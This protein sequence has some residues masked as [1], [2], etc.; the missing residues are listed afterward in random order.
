[1]SLWLRD[2]SI[3]LP[4]SSI[5]RKPLT[6]AMRADRRVECKLNEYH[7]KNIG[8]FLRGSER[9]PSFEDPTLFFV[10]VLKDSQL[11]V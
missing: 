11:D 5:T 4:T 3:Q 6:Q 2:P 1:V 7:T 10:W 9:S 8:A